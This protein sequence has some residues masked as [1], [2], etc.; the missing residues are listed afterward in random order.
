M[1]QKKILRLLI[2][3]A[4]ILL[5]GF[6]ILFV[7]RDLFRYEYDTLLERNFIPERDAHRDY[8]VFGPITLKEGSYNLSL[9]MTVE[10]R[11]SGD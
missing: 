11:G 7:N 2:I 8:V 9:E 10:G 5:T 3:L 4:T 1:H 6:G